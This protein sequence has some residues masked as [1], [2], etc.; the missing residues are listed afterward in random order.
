MW[1]CL[2]RVVAGHARPMERADTGETHDSQERYRWAFFYSV[3]GDLQFISH[4]DT[5]RLFQRVLA[6]AQVPV[7]YTRGFNPHP[8]IMIPLP[9]PVGIA[10]EVEVMVVETDGTID[11]DETLGRLAS[12]MPLGLRM[13]GGRRLAPGERLE[14]CSV[15]YRLEL[16]EPPSC[17]LETSVRRILDSDEIVVQRMNPGERQPRSI[18]VRSYLADMRVDGEVVEFTLR[19]TGSGTAKPAE[20]A[21]LL[22]FDAGSISHR[23]RRLEIEWR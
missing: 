4:H 14:P 16:G 18:D 19:V 6:R 5:L 12:R 7:R 13:T 1:R 2:R 9:R 22:G 3:D 23:I 15:R 17:G 10:S 21:A 8:R 20:I 11:V